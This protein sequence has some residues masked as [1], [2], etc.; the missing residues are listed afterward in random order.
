MAMSF[1]STP[2]RA[3]MRAARARRARG[4]AWPVRLALLVCIGV[5]I[6]QEPRLS[7]WAHARMQEAVAYG[8]AML[9][10]APGSGA[11]LARMNGGVSSSG[12]GAGLSG[13]LVEVLKR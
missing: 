6:W 13:R 1:H 11:L 7:P 12:N 3:E 10:G 8:G 9:E 2:P 4:W 5:A